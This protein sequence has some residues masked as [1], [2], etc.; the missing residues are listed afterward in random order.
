M[1]ILYCCIP[2]FATAL[3]RRGNPNLVHDPLVL[4]GPDERVFAASAE[5]AACG[6]TIGQTAR[7]AE[8]RCPE[9]RLLETDIARCRSEF[10][11][12]LELLELTSPT[13]EPHGWGAAYVDLGE[14]ARQHNEAVTLCQEIGRAVRR[15]LGDLLQPAL[16]W[17]ST[18]FTAQAAAAD[19]RPGK[20]RAVA[21]VRE[22]AFL[23][24]LSIVLLPLGR[25]ALQR[26][27]FLGL[28][29]LGQYAALPPGAVWQQFGRAGRLAQRCARG[30]D[31]R[32]VVPRSQEQHLIV[33][34]NLEDP[35]A[36]Q[37]Q[38]LAM[39]RHMVS[40]LL[41][42]LRANL[43]VCGHLRLIV[44]FANGSIQEGERSFLFPTAEQAR[45]LAMLQ[46]LLTQ[47]HW[48]AEA[49]ALEV[50]LDRI[51][52]VVAAQLPLFAAATERERKLHE[53]QR[54]IAARF[55]ANRLRRAVLSQPAAPLPEWRV[56]WLEGEP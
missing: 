29:T 34:R 48:Q 12:L 22:Y 47:L 45:V 40:P 23:Q 55:G 19:T 42:K 30:K 36:V 31:N 8:V 56:G 17:D 46:Q 27:G 33:H 24:P 3:V 25:D 32:P 28:R 11:T 39:L 15:E 16:G 35:L 6:V 52:D 44:H 38:L 43:K 26:L 7:A 54:Y 1:S 2:H 41:A 53:V 49:T 51:Q 4:I 50:A 21:P 37:E 18:K 13:V 5:A 9:A 14:L 10:E 20:L